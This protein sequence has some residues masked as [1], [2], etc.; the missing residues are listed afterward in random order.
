VLTACRRARITVVEVTGAQNLSN[1]FY[2]V[3]P[4]RNDRFLRVTPLM[5]RVFGDMDFSGCHFTGH[6]LRDLHAVAPERAAIVRQ[7]LRETWVQR[8]GSL[9]KRIG[10]PVVLLWFAGHGPDGAGLSEAPGTGPALVDRVL[11]DRV[12]PLAQR[13]IEV[14]PSDAA[15]G[16]GTDGMVFDITQARAAAELL[17]PTAHQDAARALIAALPE[18]AR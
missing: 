10:G 1:R 9:L 17:G 13:V 3:H 16:A 15:R 5:R 4:R 6:L 18:L 14:T 7:D 12:A 2:T 11:L 8:M